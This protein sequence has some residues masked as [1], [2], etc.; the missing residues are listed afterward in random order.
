[1]P[2]RGGLSAG[3]RPGRVEACWPSSSLRAAAGGE[4]GV[5]QVQRHRG[6]HGAPR[7]S[8]AVQQH[9]LRHQDYVADVEG[10]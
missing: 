3:D 2:R 5:Q 8:K 10:V 4:S 7:Q 6:K 9:G 1:M